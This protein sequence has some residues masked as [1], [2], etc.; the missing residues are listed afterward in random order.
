M[1]PPWSKVLKGVPTGW[2]SRQAQ[3]SLQ[4]ASMTFAQLP[5]PL[6]P[7]TESGT[8][9]WT[10]A[11]RVD[12]HATV[13][14]GVLALRRQH[15]LCAVMVD[16][17]QTRCGISFWKG[18]ESARCGRRRCSGSCRV[19]SRCLT[20]WK[21]RLDGHDVVCERDCPVRTQHV[22]SSETTIEMGPS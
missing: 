17:S 7:G 4:N 5:P 16:A 15:P 8:F 22:Y 11:F 19:V 2:V 1:V 6:A 3:R 21:L 14:C 9:S 18:D 10:C 20:R 12:C 13:Q